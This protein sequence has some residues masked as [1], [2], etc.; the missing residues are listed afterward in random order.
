MEFTDTILDLKL[1]PRY[2]R[3]CLLFIFWFQYIN[4]CVPFILLSTILKSLEYTN[5]SPLYS[6]VSDMFIS[7]NDK[8]ISLIDLL[9]YYSF[10]RY[11]ID[12][13]NRQLIA[14]LVNCRGCL[15][16]IMRQFRNSSFRQRH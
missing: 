13:A 7:T 16:N 12:C 2:I 5:T 9:L 14:C 4:Y 3:Y 8:V 11:F 10:T 6:L 1:I 15:P